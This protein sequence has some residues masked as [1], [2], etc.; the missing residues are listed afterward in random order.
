MKLLLGIVVFA[1]LVGCNAQ[2][3]TNQ[4]FIQITDQDY[5]VVTNLKTNLLVKAYE[6]QDTTLLNKILH[7]KYQLVDDGGEVYSK[8]SEMDYVSKYGPSYDSFSFDIITLEIFSNG[9]A[10]IFGKGTIKGTNIQGNYNQSYKRTDILVKE[11][12]NWKFI[13]SHVS[14]VSESRE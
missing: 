8:S 13:T 12:T 3:T 4:P 7:E 6:E 1:V 9:T 11:G 10:M 2:T 14:G 5:Q